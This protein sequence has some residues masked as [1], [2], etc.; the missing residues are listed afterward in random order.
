MDVIGTSV[1]VMFISILG[2]MP[3][4]RGSAF[5]L[6]DDSDLSRSSLSL[7]SFY[8]IRY[9]SEL[10]AVSMTHRDYYFYNS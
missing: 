2:W 10:L 1:F 4:G 3:M 9:E 5:C 7:Q 8:A 6:I